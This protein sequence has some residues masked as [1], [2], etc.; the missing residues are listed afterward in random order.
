MVKNRGCCDQELSKQLKDLGIKQTSMYYWFTDGI[1]NQLSENT[2]Y[3]RGIYGYGGKRDA[4][5]SA[6]TAS[7]LGNMLPEE[8]IYENAWKDLTINVVG[9]HWAVWYDKDNKRKD[10]NLAD[11]MA[12]MLI[13]LIESGFVK[14]QEIQ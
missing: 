8:V 14:A 2:D 13:Y 10:N 1:N 6:F 4:K 9:K 12:K 5:Y 7:E 3:I 11:A